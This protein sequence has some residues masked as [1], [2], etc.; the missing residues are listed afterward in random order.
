MLDSKELHILALCRATHAVP[1]DGKQE[2][3]VF[4]IL[5]LLASCEKVHHEIWF[6]R[7][8]HHEEYVSYLFELRFYNTIGDT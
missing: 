1:A 8:V 7:H 2:V 5:K 4:T 3:C 6:H